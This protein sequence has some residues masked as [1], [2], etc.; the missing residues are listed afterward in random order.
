L[1]LT[2][3]ASVVPGDI[4]IPSSIY[5]DMSNPFTAQGD[6]SS[7][8]DASFTSPFNINLG[9]NRFQAGNSGDQVRKGKWTVRHL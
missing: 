7:G 5:W 4:V 3:D 2:S 1:D 6:K 8:T 9:D